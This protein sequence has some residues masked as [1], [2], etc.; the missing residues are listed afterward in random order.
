MRW[1]HLIALGLL[2][3]AAPAFAADAPPH[4]VWQTVDGGG[5]MSTGGSFRVQGSTGQS[6]AGISTG[7]PF[8]LYG[9][10]WHPLRAAP[11]TG[12]TLTY[13]QAQRFGADVQIRWGTRTEVNTVGYRLDRAAPC[14]G[15]RI[16]VS[17]VESQGSQGGDYAII[18]AAP[19][20]PTC[21]I[22]VE[23][24]TD[25]TTAEIAHL[26]IGETVYLPLLGRS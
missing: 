24:I 14:D 25:G 22:L 23:L 12:V 13:A 4:A 11:T 20:L 1:R 7:G 5:G 18:D 26:V 10:Y 2:L 6:D 15:P 21:Y 17:Q 3:I 8:R 19:P 16:T 9:G